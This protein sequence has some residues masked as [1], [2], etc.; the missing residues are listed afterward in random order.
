MA[1]TKKNINRKSARE[2]ANQEAFKASLDDLFDVAHQDAMKIITIEEDRHFLQ[3][4]REKG[5]RGTMVGVDR[6][7]YNK[8]QRVLKRKAAASTYEKRMK[9]QC[10]ATV[11]STPSHNEDPQQSSSKSK[12]ECDCDFVIP[13]SSRSNVSSDSTKSGSGKL[14]MVSMHIAAFIRQNKYK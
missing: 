11:S 6:K 1:E 10:A 3:A 14:S 8:E 9:S 7:L 5:R 13:P 12:D 4:Q 2:V